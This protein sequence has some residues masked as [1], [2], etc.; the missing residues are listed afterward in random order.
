MGVSSLTQCEL[1]Q[2]DKQQGRARRAYFALDN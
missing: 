1:E 2:A